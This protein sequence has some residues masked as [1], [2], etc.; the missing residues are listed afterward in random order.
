MFKVAARCFS[1]RV[2]HPFSTRLRILECQ[3]R[4]AGQDADVA[5]KIDQ[6]L[7]A[8]KLCVQPL[9]DNL[10]RRIAVLKV[11]IR[12]VVD[13]EHM[14]HVDWLLKEQESAR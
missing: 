9:P 2:P 14:R 6:A 8:H 12:T 10:C 1:S 13:K 7:E 5:K 4:A 3:F 11:Q